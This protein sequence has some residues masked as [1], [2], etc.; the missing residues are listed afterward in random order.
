[1]IKCISLQK[2]WK[3]GIFTKTTKYT[4]GK[5]TRQLKIEGSQKHSGHFKLLVQKK[6]L[7]VIN[8]SRTQWSHPIQ[9]KFDFEA[10]VWNDYCWF[11]RSFW[12]CF[13]F[14]WQEKSGVKEKTEIK[15]EKI[16]TRFNFFGFGEFFVVL[17]KHWSIDFC[18]YTIFHRKQKFIIHAKINFKSYLHGHAK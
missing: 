14:L 3:K 1:M 11:L 2:K 17:S 8:F 7:G 16:L 12:S 10:H 13:N 18:P 15:E 9:L 5:Q 6:K 4:K